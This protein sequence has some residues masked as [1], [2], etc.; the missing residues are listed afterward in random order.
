MSFIR[1]SAPA[2]LKAT[3]DSLANSWPVTILAMMAYWLG[4]SIS[5]HSCATICGNC[6]A[7]RDRATAMMICETVG[8]GALGIVAP[9]LGAV[10]AHCPFIDPEAV[11]AEIRDTLSRRY[12]QLVDAN[13]RTEAGQPMQTPALE[14]FSGEMF[15]GSSASNCT[16][17]GSFTARRSRAVRMR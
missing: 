13:L 4:Y 14:V 17:S 10:V 9:M 11:R 7:N 16:P 15:A 3:A 8:A 5:G 6:L 1:L 2:P 12:R